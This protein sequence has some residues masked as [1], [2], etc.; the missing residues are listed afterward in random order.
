MA[1]PDQARKA[2][3]TRPEQLGTAGQSPNVCE[4]MCVQENQAKG[5]GYAE[6]SKPQRE[7]G[8]SAAGRGRGF[9]LTLS[10]FSNHQFINIKFHTSGAQV[11]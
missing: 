9:V 11:T 5:P 8:G 1:E 4:C 6:P 2:G 3:L 10:K 7:P